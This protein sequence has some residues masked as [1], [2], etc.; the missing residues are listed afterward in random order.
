[1]KGLLSNN[2]GELLDEHSIWL[3]IPVFVV[4]FIVHAIRC[5]WV[6]R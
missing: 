3:V 6:I 1:M 5:H 4:T 2:S